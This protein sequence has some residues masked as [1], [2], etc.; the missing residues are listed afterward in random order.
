MK[1]VEEKTAYQIAVERYETSD[2][3]VVI[4]S[5]FPKRY[6]IYQ[7]SKKS[8]F[9]GFMGSVMNQ[10]AESSRMYHLLNGIFVYERWIEDAISQ[11][12]ELRIDG[13]VK[14]HMIN[15][16]QHLINSSEGLD[17]I[18]ILNTNGVISVKALTNMNVE[19]IRNY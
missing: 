16:L 7:G 11:I 10:P 13:N 12:S 1:E 2:A 19:F 14:Q 8:V 6:L 17:K 9:S 3:D 5:E 18:E 4:V 15:S